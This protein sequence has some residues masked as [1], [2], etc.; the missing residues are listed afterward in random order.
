MNTIFGKYDI[1][2]RYGREINKNVFYK[3]GLAIIASYHPSRIVI[4]HDNRPHSKEL[5]RAIISAMSNHGV[6]VYNTGMI[7]T[8]GIY[9]LSQRFDMGLMVTASHLPLNMNG[10]KIV[11]NGEAI[12]IDTG[13]EKIKKFFNT[14]LRKK[15]ERGVITNKDLKPLYYR[16]LSRFIPKRKIDQKILIDPGNNSGVIYKTLLKNR[17]YIW[18]NTSIRYNKKRDPNPFKRGVISNLK[19]EK[20]MRNC[21]IALAFDGDADRLMVIDEESRLLP[22]DFVGGIIAMNNKQWRN[23][24]I[25]VDVRTSQGVIEELKNYGYHVIIS[26]CGHT[27]VNEAMRKHKAVFGFETSGHYYFRSFKYFDNAFIAITKILNILSKGRD[28]KRESERFRYYGFIG[29][30]N[31]ETRNKERFL[32]MLKKIFPN[33]KKELYIDGLSLYFNDYWFN[34]RPSNTEPVVRIR[35]E[36]KTRELGEMILRE[37]KKMKNK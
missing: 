2:G 15:E 7:T 23:E 16:Y 35:L 30:V 29:E 10:L 19:R 26:R 32:Y 12:G 27:F 31:I 22:P 21:S 17:N 24:K 8:P 9:Y 3:L 18:I 11:R 33:P 14:E 4:G 28:L 25:I 5:V 36:A 1:R 13:L 6:R 34:A 20:K 37:I